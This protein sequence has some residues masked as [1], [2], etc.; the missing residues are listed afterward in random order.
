[1]PR[2]AGKLQHASNFT[3][4]DSLSTENMGAFEQVTGT[5]HEVNPMIRV[6]SNT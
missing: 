3:R 5:V 4:D 6:L 2:R 1:M